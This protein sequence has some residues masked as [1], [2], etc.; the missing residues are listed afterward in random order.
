MEYMKHFEAWKNYEGLDLELKHE[1][2]AMK[3]DQIKV[4]AVVMIQPFPAYCLYPFKHFIFRSE[5]HNASQ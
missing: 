2:L 4:I 1:L 5:E 3:E